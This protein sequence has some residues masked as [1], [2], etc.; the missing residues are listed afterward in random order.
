MATATSSSS[1]LR[2]RK[3]VS[4]SSSS[5]S[6]SSTLHGEQQEQQQHFAGARTTKRRSTV[7]YLMG[8]LFM[9]SATAKLLL[10]PSYKSTDF[11]VHRHWKAVTRHL[12]LTE[13]YFDDEHVQ[14]FHTFDY[15]PGFAWFEYMWSHLSVLTING[16][17][18]ERCL[19]LL[20]DTDNEVSLSCVTFMRSTV[21]LS[22]IILW[23][24]A[25]AIS[26][27]A[28]IG[29][30]SSSSTRTTRPSP[31]AQVQ[32]KIQTRRCWKIFLLIVFHPGLLWLDH[33]HFQYNG[34]LLGVLLLSLAC[35]LQANNHNHNTTQTSTRSQKIAFHG[36]HLAAAI[37][38]AFLLTLKH[39]YLI[40]AP[41]YFCY[42]LQRYVLT[43]P[44]TTPTTSL[45][46][47]LG[48]V[49]R[50]LILGVVTLTTLILPVVPFLVAPSG[51]GNNATTTTKSPQQQL[52]QMATRLFPFGRGLVHDYWAGNV[53]ALHQAI[54]KL[55]HAAKLQDS[56]LLPDVSPGQC[57]V[58]LLLS[59]LP[60]CWYGYKAA[61]EQNNER[62]VLSV[63]Y[64]AVAS[65]LTAYHV[66]EKAI[67]TSLL[68]LTVWA[69][70]LANRPT[71]SST[72]YTKN[73]TKNHPEAAPLRLLT[74]M[75]AA[76]VLGLGPLLFRPVEMLLKVCTLTPYL[77]VLF[78]LC[79][80]ECEEEEEQN[81]TTTPEE[82]SLW[83]AS[84]EDTSTT[85]LEVLGHIC[86]PRHPPE[87]QQ[88]TQPESSLQHQNW[89]HSWRCQRL[90]WWASIAWIV[91]VWALVEM[92]PVR[93]WG[94]Y[95]FVPLAVTS[96]SVAVALLISFARI[97]YRMVSP[98]NPLKRTTATPTTGTNT[99]APTRPLTSRPT[100]TP[101]TPPTGTPSKAPMRPPASCPTIT[102]TTPPKGT[103]T[104]APTKPPT[105]CPTITLTT[106]PKGTPTKAP[107]RP[108]TS[109][110]T[111]KPTKPPT[112][113]PN[114]RPPGPPPRPP[115]GPP[116]SPPTIPL[117]NPPT[118]PPN[119]PPGP[120]PSPPTIPSTSR[121]TRSPNNRPPGPP[122][123][124]SK[125]PSTHRPMKSPNNR[126]PGPPPSHP[127]RTLTSPPTKTPTTPLTE[128][129]T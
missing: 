121:P 39:L 8:S 52:V 103:P 38:F 78:H 91:P 102:L 90:L 54:N 122:T 129:Q 7:M 59:L 12:P 71:T 74:Q 116:A 73:R 118:I 79:Q 126:P 22:D 76:A 72:R 31:S 107:T 92:V 127:M 20:P 75:T 109:G 104:K 6:E 95:E 125:I 41:W 26:W 117:T 13:W 53:W 28:T 48:Q 114:N 60:G 68:P 93:V 119:R 115:P 124:P 101:T 42:L 64:S 29:S 111:R 100:R 86:E 123:S 16:M 98:T 19:S 23:L 97:T 81:M 67:L 45:Y 17:L 55:L 62:L 9:L 94:R 83:S 110:P 120:P 56:L 88:P 44:T 11:D 106:P 2:R 85:L 10:I 65:F 46:Q 50:L 4:P 108:P 84:T 57:A 36:Y 51:P 14:T 43:A 80:C 96:V 49:Q 30:M 113:T 1:T 69:V 128:T 37:V 33:V 25:G 3:K 40:L 89:F 66:H 32:T 58:L 63:T 18:D 70:G 61:T 47:R 87:Q 21:I 24:G 15:P 35:L 5:S 105:S 34:M 77:A 112:R 99:K 27:A 82:L